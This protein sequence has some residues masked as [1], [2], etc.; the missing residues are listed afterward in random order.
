MIH[1]R[2]HRTPWESNLR[3]NRQNRSDQT[4]PLELDRMNTVSVVLP[5][6]NEA[7]CIG[8]LLDRIRD[9]LHGLDMT[10]EVVVVDDGSDDSTVEIVEQ[11]AARMPI[12]ILRHQ[13]NSGYGAALQT[14]LLEAIPLSE[15]VI[16]MDA[17]DSHDPVLIPEMLK[18]IESGNDVVIASRMHRGG[19]VVGVPIHRRLLSEVASRVLRI[20]MPVQGV[21]DFTSGYR[22]Y[23]TT[24]LKS[25][26]EHQAGGPLLSEKGFA[27][28][29]ELLRKVRNGG[30]T[31]TEVPLVL[32][33]DRKM[34]ASRMRIL[35]TSRD[36]LRLLSTPAGAGRS[37]RAVSIRGDDGW[38]HS[39]NPDRAA[40]VATVASDIIFVIGA[41]AAAYVLYGWAL[42][43]GWVEQPR[44]R[45]LNL[46]E[47]AG[48]FGLVSVVVLWRSGQYRGRAAVLNIRLLQ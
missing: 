11:R 30:A 48:L 36:Y 13:R 38:P 25:M 18:A 15:V 7:A 34:S 35:A 45:I 23:R 47:M 28:G 42:Q 6:Y 21:R 26:V 3:L 5:A 46:M 8:T 27:A 19:R 1:S 14:G 40:V 31:V 16:T 2:Y 44:P 22:A 43:V 37:L 24:M 9:S 29:L 4:K 17:D 41:F 12:R 33:Y 10:Y 39:R 32:R 20:S